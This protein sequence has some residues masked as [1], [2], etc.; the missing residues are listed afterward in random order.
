MLKQLFKNAF[1]PKEAKF[2]FDVEYVDG[3]LNHNPIT[4]F[5]TGKCTLNFEKQI[6]TIKQNDNILTENMTDVESIRT[7][8]LNRKFL[9]IQ[10]NTKTHNEYKF[11]MDMS[12]DEKVMY[13][14]LMQPLTKY[15]DAFGIPITFDGN[16]KENDKDN[17]SN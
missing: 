4:N 17:E 9:F 12:M 15:A 2:G 8:S 13:L 3:T 7:W 10:F 5:Q 14:I 16:F 11:K 6:M 1:Q